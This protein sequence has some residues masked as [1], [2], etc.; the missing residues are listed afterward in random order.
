MPPLS[1][2][3]VPFL[4]LLRDCTSPGCFSTPLPRSPWTASQLAASTRGSRA[5]AR[6]CWG[7]TQCRQRSCTTGAGGQCKAGRQGASFAPLGRFGGPAARTP[8]C[9]VRPW[10]DAAVPRKMKEAGRPLQR[11]TTAPRSCRPPRTGMRSSAACA[12][13]AGTSCAA[14]S[15]AVAPRVAPHPLA[16]AAPARTPRRP[17]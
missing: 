11:T 8:R 6:S 16:S 14:V 2:A 5:A 15:E 1:P 7:A 13:T 10:C 4:C 9:P 17:L 12:G 3:H